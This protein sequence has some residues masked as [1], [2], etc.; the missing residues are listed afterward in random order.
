[1][2]LGYFRKEQICHISGYNWKQCC[3]VVYS[4]RVPC[5][6]GFYKYNTGLGI[7][8]ISGF[9]KWHSGCNNAIGDVCSTCL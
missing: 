2:I 1:M 5:D 8:P 4:L 9:P 7:G 6:V 3:L